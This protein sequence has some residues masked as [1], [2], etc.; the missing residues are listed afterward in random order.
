MFL[1]EAYFFQLRALFFLVLSQIGIRSLT[2][3]HNSQ[4]GLKNELRC[5]ILIIHW[6]SWTS[7]CI[8]WL[9]QTC[10]H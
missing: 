1:I 8:L 5:A 7:I 4:T 2:S 6:F 10:E 9:Q 3:L